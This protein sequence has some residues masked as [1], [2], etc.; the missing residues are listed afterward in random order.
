[1]KLFT[2]QILSSPNAESFNESVI[3]AAE[4]VYRTIVAEMKEA[5]IELDPFKIP[6]FEA[7]EEWIF[8]LALLTE[9]KWVIKNAVFIEFRCQGSDYFGLALKRDEESWLSEDGLK[10]LNASSTKSHEVLEYAKMSIKDFL[11]E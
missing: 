8:F 7:T 9:D 2:D 1:M 6:Q 10:H 4:R 5:D 3:R 11:T